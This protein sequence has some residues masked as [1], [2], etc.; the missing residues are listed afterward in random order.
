[1][2]KSII[3]TAESHDI[4]I[5]DS[6]GDSV[7]PIDRTAPPS[8]ILYAMLAL[9]TVCTPMVEIIYKEGNN[10]FLFDFIN[11]TWTL[12]FPKIRMGKNCDHN[13]II[14]AFFSLYNESANR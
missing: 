5:S 10:T 4:I 1:M 12:T 6:D 7:I 2:S 14:N 9:A 11:E 13:E 8:S 3:Y